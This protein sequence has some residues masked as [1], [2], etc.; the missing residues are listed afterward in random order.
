MAELKRST[1]YKKKTRRNAKQIYQYVK[2]HLS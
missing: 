1:Q 2:Y